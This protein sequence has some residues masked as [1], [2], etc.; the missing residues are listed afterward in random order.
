[1]LYVFLQISS[2]IDQ[3][4]EHKITIHTLLKSQE[5]RSHL[6]I[7][8]SHDS[9]EVPGQNTRE[10]IVGGENVGY[11]RRDNDIENIWLNWKSISS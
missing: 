5:S 2:T 4:T 10:D 1:M 9:L 6:S 11:H 8:Q 3:R 7:S